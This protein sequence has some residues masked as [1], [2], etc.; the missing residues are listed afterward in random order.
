MFQYYHNFLYRHQNSLKIEIPSNVF[1]SNSHK[2]QH[3]IITN[4]KILILHENNFEKALI[5]RCLAEWFCSCSREIDSDS[6]T[7]L[8]D[9]FQNRQPKP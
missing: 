1:F 6:P 3:G 5:S 7:F 4:F 8:V 2:E 9:N